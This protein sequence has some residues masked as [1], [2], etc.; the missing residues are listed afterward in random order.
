MVREDFEDLYRYM[1]TAEEALRCA[2]NS[3]ID[4]YNELYYGLSLNGEI[5]NYKDIKELWDRLSYNRDK[6][7]N[8]IVREINDKLDSM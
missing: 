3:L 8:I 6:I 4:Y 2:Y 5:Y 1:S 7:N